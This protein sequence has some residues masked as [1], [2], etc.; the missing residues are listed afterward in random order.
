M[1]SRNGTKS[2]WLLQSDKEVK[3]YM[4]NEEVAEAM[5]NALMGKRRETSAPHEPRID[6]D[7][8]ANK[9]RLKIFAY[10]ETDGEGEISGRTM[11]FVHEQFETTGLQFR[12]RRE[13]AEFVMNY[14]I[15]KLVWKDMS[16]VQYGGSRGH[17]VLYSMSQAE[18]NSKLLERAARKA[19]ARGK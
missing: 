11:H 5:V 19:E 3:L 18:L 4:K 12:T 9:L 17:R 6:L 2:R 15:A 7:S 14:S 13:L 1:A 8:L 16:L 10:A